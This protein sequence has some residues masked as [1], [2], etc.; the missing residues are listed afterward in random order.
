MAPISAGVPTSPG[1]L[2]F[3]GLAGSREAILGWV[4]LTVA[5]LVTVVVSLLTALGIQRRRTLEPTPIQDEG[6]G[7]GWI[8]I[9]GI[10]VP[11]IILTGVFVLTMRT[12]A[13]VA[14]PAGAPAL[15]VQ[16]TGHR[17][18]WEVRYLDASPLGLA[19]TANEIHIP[20][21]QRVR[22]EL[23]SADVIHSFWIPELGG[24]TDLI[25]GQRNVTWLE[26]DSAGVYRGQCAEYCG[27]QH[28]K[29]AM[30]IVADPAGG[31]CALAR[32]PAPAGGGPRGF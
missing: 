26:A 13:A 1:V 4:L 12:Q 28:A 31:V 21:G 10:I 14:A 27:M 17:W 15:T 6:G 16:I 19:V 2:G 30:S 3:H 20:V 8:V 7:V 11:A 5:M 23:V 32:P 24:K 9:G 25:P 29:M 22:F 18:W